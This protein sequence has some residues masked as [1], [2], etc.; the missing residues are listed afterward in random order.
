VKASN[1]DQ[2][3]FVTSRLDGE[4]GFDPFGPLK[5]DAPAALGE[6]KP[7]LSQRAKAP[8]SPPAPTSQPQAPIAPPLP[9]VAIGSIVGS[10]LA[11][12]QPIAFLQAQ[13]QLLVVKAGDAAGPNYRVE[14]I[15]GRRVEFTYLPLGQRQSL[16]LSP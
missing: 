11:G 15:S 5:I 14:S 3:A 12:G 4:V 16:T 7:Q 10:D 2:A 8:P 13:G 1:T 6:P 9:F